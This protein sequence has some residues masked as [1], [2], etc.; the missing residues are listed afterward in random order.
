[1]CAAS[2]CYSCCRCVC[3]LMHCT[4]YNSGICKFNSSAACSSACS[5]SSSSRFRFATR[6]SPCL[7]R[8]WRAVVNRKFTRLLLLA[9]LSLW[10][11]SKLLYATSLSFI[12]SASSWRPNDCCAPGPVLVGRVNFH[13][14]SQTLHSN[15]AHIIQFYSDRNHSLHSFAHSIVFPYSFPG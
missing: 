6:P 14:G 15:S 3:K 7:L 1:M 13:Q 9:L 11:Q 12:A 2:F 10:S 4:F 5:A 8:L